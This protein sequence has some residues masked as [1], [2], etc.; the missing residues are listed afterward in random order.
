[1][2]LMAACF[3]GGILTAQFAATD[4]RAS[5]LACITFAL[6]ALIF[7]KTGIATVLIAI[8]FAAAGAASLQAELNSVRPNRLKVLYDN[9]SIKSGSPV[10]V[11]GVLLGRPEP[12]VDGE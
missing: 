9:G 4:T 11:E 2:L 3:A 7:R 5:F 1:M 6:L 10:E 12:S 8:A